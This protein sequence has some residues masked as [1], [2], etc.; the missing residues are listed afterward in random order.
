M[1]QSKSVAAGVRLSL[2][3]ACSAAIQAQEPRMLDR[4]DTEVPV[5]YFISEGAAGSGYR[6]SDQELAIWALEAWE[7]NA[8]G[9]LRFVPGPEATALLR[10]YWVPA[11]SGQYGEMRPLLVDGRRGAEVFIR[12][13]T[14]ALGQEIGQRA[15]T[16]SLF[17]DT[18][19]YLT[20]LHE[21]G[22]ALGL[23]HTSNYNDIMYF[24]GFGGDIPGFFERYRNQLQS[25]QDIANFAGLSNG[26]LQRLEA[27]YSSTLA[28]GRD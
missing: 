25:R 1:P 21:L 8:N 7:R 28:G 26:D 11:G 19:V 22:H 12:P 6:D 16:D 17:R 13:N 14:D 4:L 5:T 10:V 15:R 18:V 23:S 3:L 20:C 27:L 9:T 24:F 2:F